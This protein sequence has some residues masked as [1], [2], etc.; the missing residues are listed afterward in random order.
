MKLIRKMVILLCSIIAALAFAACGQ[1]EEEQE[2][3][4][5]VPEALA[6]NP[7]AETPS[8]GPWSRVSNLQIS[9]EY[10]YF[11]YSADTGDSIKRIRLEDMDWSMAESV[12]PIYTGNDAYV[13][14]CEQSLYLYENTI[15]GNWADY[16]ITGVNLYKYSSEG[17]QV[18]EYFIPWEDGR[19]KIGGFAADE[20]C[21]L[22]FLTED[23]IL[24]LDRNGNP[25]G[26]IST[27]AYNKGS[28][29]HE[30][31]FGDEAGNV[32]YAFYNNGSMWRV[33]QVKDGS[34]LEEINELELGNAREIEPARDGNLFI[35]DRVNGRLYEYDNRTTSMELVL[36]F[37]DSDLSATNVQQFLRLSPD[38]LLVKESSRMYRFTKKPA[39]EVAQRDEIVI[40]TF[41]PT[42]YLTNAVVEFNKQDNG[43]YV[44][45]EQY[46]D[47]SGG[48]G[49]VVRLDASLTSSQPPDLLYLSD[50]SIYKYASQGVMADLSPYLEQSSEVKKEDYLDNLIEGFTIDGRLVCIPTRMAVSYYI[51]RRSQM[52]GLNGWSM[53]DLM[54]LT[55]QFPEACLINGRVHWSI[56]KFFWLPYIMERFLDWE[57]WECSFDSEEFREQLYWMKGVLEVSPDEYPTDDWMFTT[58]PIEDGLLMERGFCTFRELAINTVF[59]NGE[60]VIVGRPTANGRGSFRCSTWDALGIVENSA[61]KEDA[62]KFLEYYLMRQRKPSGDGYITTYKKSLYQEAEEAVVPDYI[63]DEDG[64]IIL[65][66]YG[67]PLIRSRVFYLWEGENYEFFTAPQELVD[68]VLDGITSYDFAPI[69]YRDEI[70][71]IILEEAEGCFYGNKSAEETARVIQS[72]VS[73]LLN[74]RK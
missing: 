69:P 35:L 63:Y 52:E 34:R 20:E 36:Y 2:R 16:V 37:T 32:Y 23:G 42:I 44:R 9:G 55:E 15:E 11:F 22:L 39:S 65:D 5:Y 26:I 66:R 56:L 31:L 71:A 8:S 53:K 51:V 50:Q 12:L 64:N 1:E 41:S 38:E 13:I 61:R 49:G 7:S 54:N 72:R 27:A 73:L 17:E 40:A 48:D 67:D 59:M 33:M 62:W 4:V 46:G 43:F 24:A 45:I 3:Y 29:F 74:E 10:L 6:W 57:D 60:G 18:Y 25:R 21:N 70:E 47:D 19:G 58:I 14:D 30:K 28:G 68:Q